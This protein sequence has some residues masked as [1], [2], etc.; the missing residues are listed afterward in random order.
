MQR[1]W[2]AL[3]SPPNPAASAPHP[4][5]IRPRWVGDRWLPQDSGLS[6]SEALGLEGKLEGQ[7]WSG[8]SPPKP[9]C[10]A[11]GPPEARP[12]DTRGIP[13][14]AQCAGLSKGLLPL[15]WPEGPCSQK[16]GQTLQARC[17]A[18]VPAPEGEEE[19]GKG[20]PMGRAWHW[21]A[22]M[23]SCRFPQPTP[24]GSLDTCPSHKRSTTPFWVVTELETMPKGCCP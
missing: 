17:A 8:H 13:P 12:A 1:T 18:A 16:P 19:S 21:G 7:G 3:R 6:E 22:G 2:G 23:S 11:L 10:S 20:G 4:P 15:C 5:R 14:R 24:G 9:I